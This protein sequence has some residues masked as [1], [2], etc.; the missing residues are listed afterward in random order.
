L[1]DLDR[2]T[3]WPIRV[4]AI[5]SGRRAPTRWVAWSAMRR[6][7]IRALACHVVAVTTAVVVA[8][9]AQTV[10]GRARQATPAA[11]DPGRSYGYVDDR[12]GLL[13]DDSVKELLGAEH[14]AR[15]YSGA[16]CQYVLSGRAGLVDVVYSWFET[17]S[18]E[19]ERA[20]AGSRG[21]RLVD[22]DVARHPA[23][24]GQRPDN[25]AACTATA[26]AGSGVLTW[27][28][29]FR[30]I[31]AQQPCDAAEQLLSATLS[32]DM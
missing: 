19:R 20:L 31:G 25:A 9:C 21:L 7:L 22:K 3:P 16:V 26:A 12:C 13:A 14:V 6:Q 24:L 2:G 15:P 5:V 17:G 27:W 1:L 23:F 28:V 29:Q 8:G 10:D 30:P 4:R 32:A 18:L 11:P